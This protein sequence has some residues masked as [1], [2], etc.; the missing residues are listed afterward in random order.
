MFGVSQYAAGTIPANSSIIQASKA[1]MTPL[2]EIIP[3]STITWVVA[4]VHNRSSSEA[5]LNKLDGQQPTFEVQT[6]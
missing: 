3:Q 2:A 4:T 6:I 1:T 5:I